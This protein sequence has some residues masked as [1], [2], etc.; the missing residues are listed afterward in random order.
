MT[1]IVVE[2]VEKNVYA[3]HVLLHYNS[4]HVTLQVQPVDMEPKMTVA[5]SLPL[6]MDK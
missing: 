1:V 2:H 4:H 6:P 3:H 5:E